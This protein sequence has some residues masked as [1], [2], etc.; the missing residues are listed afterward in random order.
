MSAR[1]ES[2]ANGIGGIDNWRSSPSSPLLI[3]GPFMTSDSDSSDTPSSEPAAA[4]MSPTLERLR[5]FPAVIL[6]LAM[7]AARLLPVV[8]EDGPMLFWLTAAFG[9]LLCGLAI[10][11]VWWLM[12]SRASPVERLIGLLGVVSAFGLT[13]LSIHPSMVGPGLLLLTGPLGLAAFG[14][15]GVLCGRFRSINR[16]FVMVLMAAAGFG[17]STLIRTE[18]MWGNFNMTLKW[19]WAPSAEEQLLTESDSRSSGDITQFSA[20]EVDAWLA[21]PEWPSFRGADGSGRQTSGTVAAD[22]DVQPPTELWKVGVGPGWSSF[23]VAGKLLYTQE[24]RGPEEAVVC[25]NADNGQEVWRQQIESRFSDPL[26]GP[27]PRATPTLS[28][29]RLYVQGA[30]GQVLCLDARSGDINWQQ[31]LRDLADRTPPEWGFSS[32]PL[33]VGSV[34]V[35]YAGGRDEKG[36]FGLDVNSGEVVWSAATGD[37]SYSSPQLCHLHGQDYV[38]ML[39]NAG[40]VLLEPESGEVRLDYEWATS[41]YRALQ[42]HVVDGRSLLLP[43][44][45]GEGTRRIDVTEQDGQLTA[46]ENWTNTRL[47][48]DFNDFVID[49]GFLYG[50]DGSIVCCVDLETGKRKWKRGRYGKGQILLLENSDLLLVL[51]EYGDIVLLRAD[52]TKHQEL[53]KISALEGKTWNHPVVTGE[54]LYIRNSQEAS[55]WKLP[56]VKAEPADTVQR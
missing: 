39:T 29:G 53:A 38:G 41:Q 42:P 7:L 43:T 19:R 25:F 36:V 34:V 13:W 26:G 35:A 3:P 40:I 2:V 32:S 48:P 22:W 1:K 33:V 44:G 18:G 5:I 45:L 20:E 14:V 12:L 4:T 49:D 51:G 9:P 56:I 27:G 28:D 46:E 8:F 15:G 55:C 30:N 31:D 17:F 6:L 37:H 24:Q 52:P 23:A 11:L 21:A 16:T 47:K 10:V 54:R 50:F